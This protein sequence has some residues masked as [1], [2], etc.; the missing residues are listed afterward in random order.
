MRRLTLEDVEGILDRS[1]IGS[2]EWQDDATDVTPR[3]SNDWPTG[4]ETCPYVTKMI[5]GWSTD[6][7]SNGRHPW[8]VAQC[9]RLAAALRRGCVSDSDAMKGLHILDERLRDLCMTGID[10]APRVT[11]DNET[12]GAFAW[13]IQKVERKTDDQVDE[14]LGRHVHSSPL[15][16]IEWITADPL[17]Q[18]TGLTERIG[19][20]PLSGFFVKENQ[21]WDTRC[22]VNNVYQPPLASAEGSEL[23]KTTAGRLRL[24]ITQGYDLRKPS[25]KGDGY[26]PA[27][28]NNQTILDALANPDACPR[29][30]PVREVVR[31][32]LLTPDLDLVTDPGYHSE[33]LYLPSPGQQ[34]TPVRLG[35]SQAIQF[36]RGIFHQFPWDCPGDEFNWLAALLLPIL[37]TATPEGN[38]PLVL[39]HAHQPGSGKTLL[40]QTLLTLYSG[41]MLPFPKSE[42][43][44]VKTLTSSLSSPHGVV[45]VFDNIDDLSSRALEQLL[46]SPQWS[47]RLLGGNAIATLR[48]TKL[49]V[50]TGNNCHVGKD[51]LRRTLWVSIDPK[52]ARPEERTGYEIPNLNQW[53]SQNKTSVLSYL[54]GLII[55]WRD[56]GAPMP[57]SV[58]ADSFPA[59]DIATAILNFHGVEGSARDRSNQPVQRSTDDDIL[60]EFV[61]RLYDQFGDTPFSAKDLHAAA[62]GNEDLQHSIPGNY[63][64]ETT[65]PRSIGM[66]LKR[67]EKRIV[68]DE[69]Y[70]WCVVESGRNNKSDG[71]TRNA[72]LYQVKRSARDIPSSG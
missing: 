21:V 61:C 14:E 15:D 10:G 12:F 46:T 58:P 19:D 24:A 6:R 69:E 62:I 41:E 49:W 2:L 18:L 25:S 53:M 3:S 33:Y 9:V 35:D 28:L 13:A 27:R 20:G 47:A 57:S 22:L 63:N 7:P 43:E 40:A 31:T 71:S 26:V 70:D 60:L 38:A 8:M 44:M 30:R 1:G 50:A 42:E 72:N 11:S 17:D 54:Y 66:I 23:R 29:L 16:R 4:K 34:V 32:P 51:M 52:V 65:T 64:P 67:R 37:L 68:S 45:R 39:I 36:I 59:L 5:T 56:A 55:D 48:N